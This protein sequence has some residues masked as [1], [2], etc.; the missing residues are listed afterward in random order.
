MLPSLGFTD[1]AEALLLS[2]AAT[3]LGAFRANAAQII[4]PVKT[5][6]KAR[7]RLTKLG[8]FLRTGVKD[9]RCHWRA[10]TIT[11]LLKPLEADKQ[12][13]PARVVAHAG[14]AVYGSDC[15]IEATVM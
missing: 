14:F 15:P 9:S 13:K 6:A 8:F 3:D 4:A 12:Q 1:G 2:W 5:I 11:V 10:R 7:W